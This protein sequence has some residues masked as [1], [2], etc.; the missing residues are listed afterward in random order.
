MTRNDDTYTIA[1]SAENAAIAAFDAWK[2]EQNAGGANITGNWDDTDA[3]V[4]MRSS[5]RCATIMGVNEF[6]L[7]ALSRTPEDAPENVDPDQI[8]LVSSMV[9]EFIRRA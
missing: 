5:M 1:P 3:T 7:P 4:A 2:S 9:M 6:N 8:A